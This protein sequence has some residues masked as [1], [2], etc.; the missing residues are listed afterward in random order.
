[1]IIRMELGDSSYDIVL[2]R[3]CLKKAGELLNLD[4]KVFILTDD[5]VPAQYAETVAEQCRE[6]HIHTAAQGEGSK[7]FAVLEELLTQMLDL[8]FTRG[9]CVCS[10][11]GGVV[12]DLGGFTAACYMRGIDFYN[13]PTTI[14]SQVDSSIGGKTAVNLGG[15]KNVVGAF[16]QPEKVLIDADVLKTLPPRLVSEGLA[17]ALKM[18]V[19]FDEE[20]FRIFEEEDYEAICGDRIERIIEMALRIKARVVE[21]D[22]KEQGLRK[23]LNFGHT[24]GHGIES[25]CLDGTLYHGECVSIGMLPMCSPDV[26]ARLL[27]VLEKLHLPTS[28]D[29]DPEKVLGAMKH[30]KKAAGGRIAIVETDR[31]GT[32]Y[33]ESADEVML[34]QKIALTRKGASF[35]PGTRSEGLEPMPAAWDQG[36]AACLQ[37]ASDAGSDA[38]E[39]DKRAVPADTSAYGLIGEHLPHSFSKTIHEKIGDYSYELIELRLEELDSYMRRA[40]FKGINVTIPYKQAVIPYLDEISEQARAIGAVNTVVNRG[41]KLYGYNTDY[42]GM[43]A[44]F[45]HA[46]IDPA[47]KKALI[48]GTGGT[49]RTAFAVLKDLGA[50]EVYRVSRSGRDGAITY[51]EAM[52]DHADAQILVNT[53]PCGMYPDLDGCPADLSCFPDL[54]GV[55]DAVYNPLR[56]TLVLEAQKRGIPAEGGLYMLV[57]QAVY[58]AELFTDRN[59][60]NS[61]T[62]SI[63]T[64]ILNSKRNIVLTGMSRAGKTTVG[65]LLAARLGREMMDTDQMIVGREQRA[66]T[67]IFA[68]EGEAYFRDAESEMIGVLAPQNGLVI[69]TGGGAILRQENVDTLKKNGVIV[70]LDRPVEQILPTDDRPLANTAAK[71]TALY[72]KRYP[73]YRAACDVRVV[74]DK[75][76]EEVTEKIL[77]GLGV[78]G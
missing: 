65:A 17:E 70:F 24:I 28:C 12:G 55:I 69:A 75:S 16:Y 68:T 35:A 64:E 56:T 49:S 39:G 48:L 54:A 40:A 41:G 51:E 62:E 53:T 76:A 59:I 46:G 3:G 10:V 29:M 45:G 31:I 52:Q 5:G 7:S 23:V 27:P 6:P 67:D 22:E 21:E 33:L 14:L 61:V 20:L 2:E 34:R 15:I 44:L 38:P 25:L 11:G 57:V 19:T 9:D 37:G 58:A 13:I 66:I 60:D 50:S 72:E 43:K 78:R 47:G 18:A 30:D 26:R 71:V 32:Y 1:M 42:F 74:N 4:R 8:G 36:D 77:A 63:Y 73:V